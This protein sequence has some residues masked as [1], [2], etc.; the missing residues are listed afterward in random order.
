MNGWIVPA[1]SLEPHLFLFCLAL[2]LR[3]GVRAGRP[4]VLNAHCAWL[5]A[6]LRLRPP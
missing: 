6:S 3:C 4:R 1:G 5:R 2:A